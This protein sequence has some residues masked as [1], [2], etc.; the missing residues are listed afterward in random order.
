M[1][2]RKS[3]QL[4]K[5]KGEEERLRFIYENAFRSH[6]KMQRRIEKHRRNIRIFSVLLT[7][8]AVLV[9]L[10]E[11]RKKI[12]ISFG[13]L[14]IFPLW[15]AGVFAVAL[16]GV[17]LVWNMKLKKNVRRMYEEQEICER[18]YVTA[19]Q[20]LNKTTLLREQLEEQMGITGEEGNFFCESDVFVGELSEQGKES[21]MRESIL[22][23]KEAAQLRLQAVSKR[24]QQLQ[25]EWQELLKEEIEGKEKMKKYG[26]FAILSFCAMFL[27][28]GIAMFAKYYAAIGRVGFFA[29]AFLGFAPTLF[30]WFC[31]KVETELNDAP[32]LYRLMAGGDNS[33]CICVKKN[34]IQELL[35]KNEVESLKLQ[36]E[37]KQVQLQLDG[38]T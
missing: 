35:E 27:F 16:G 18:D 14:D 36:Q 21:Q 17:Y 30:L 28:M 20:K 1:E 8:E 38:M 2:E 29:S 9:L 5:L 24:K 31:R 37:I 13:E 4:H 25:K 22:R 7:V 10:W 3:L 26:I 6:E 32:W 12:G 15:R 33:Q 23:K 34:E 11:I 19:T